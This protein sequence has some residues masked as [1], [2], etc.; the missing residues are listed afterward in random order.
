MLTIVLAAVL[1]LPPQTSDAVIGVSAIHLESGKRLSV[2]NNE[3]F[4]MG[5]VYKF[6]IALAVLRRVDIGVLSL[7]QEIT[8]EPREFAPGW[9]P[10]RDHAHGK[11]IVLPVRELL[12]HMV[13]ISDN[14]ASDALMKLIG[15]PVSVTTRLAELYASNIRVDRS[16]TQM[17][18]DLRKPGGVDTYAIDARD[19]ATPDAMAEL[20]VAFW[21]RHDGLSRA[22]HDLLVELM[23]NSQTG[24]HRIKAGVPAG[25]IVAHKTGSMPG[26]TNDVGI[27][28]SPDGKQ[29]I[30]LVVFTKASKRDKTS[31]AEKDI[32]AITA[33]V[34]RELFE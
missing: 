22:S 4:P 16:E 19:T 6:P 15:G 28:T 30:A 10:L 3:R 33:K 20:L 11:P 1:T 12:M 17:A 26:T 2:R 32:A 18:A 23:T 29:H 27:I 24:P 7:D 8:I 31:E 34:C 21:N 14:T 9:S 25:A 13:S 5:S